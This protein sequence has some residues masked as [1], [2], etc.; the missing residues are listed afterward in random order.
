MRLIR[1]LPWIGILAC[2]FSACVQA[3]APLPDSERAVLLELYDL[4]GGPSWINRNFWGGPPGSECDL[5]NP[6]SG[7]ECRL[8]ADGFNHVADIFLESNGLNGTL[9]ADFNKLTQL[10]L[11]ELS[12]NN[13]F[14]QVLSGPFPSLDGMTKLISLRAE[15]D[16]FTGPIPSLSTLTSLQA[17]NIGG[18][19][20]T[21]HIPSLDGLPELSFAAFD[22][23]NLDGPIPSLANVPKIFV[24]SASSNHLTGSIPA[25]GVV[26]SFSVHSNQLDGSIPTLGDNTHLVSFDVHSNRFTGSI[27][28]LAGV[29][30]LQ[31]FDA[32]NNLLTGSIPPLDATQIHQFMVGGNKLTG[33]VPAASP[34]PIVG[35]SNLCPNSLDL[36]PSAN[37]EGWNTATNLHPWWGAFHSRCDIL[38]RDGF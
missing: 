1:H 10:E 38:F 22:A 8:G 6:W 36:T 34:V 14:G 16:Q 31:I 2:S 17:F 32:S 30:N 35:R 9:P 25:L 37:D 20:L 33:L 7:V 5:E 13:S 26:H 29:T 19:H 23:N 24:F 4:T 15:G 21:G 27:P 3:A 18:N 28:A 12:F 11:L